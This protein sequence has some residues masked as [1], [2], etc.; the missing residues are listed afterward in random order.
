M[1]RCRTPCALPLTC[2]RAVVATSAR[3]GMTLTT[4]LHASKYQP[5]V[6]SRTIPYRRGRRGSQS[7]KGGGERIAMT[8]G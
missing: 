5:A 2:P 1:L 4:V 6:R 7:R 3:P 8:R